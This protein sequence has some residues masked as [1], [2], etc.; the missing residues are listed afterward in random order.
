MLNRFHRTELH[1][2]VQAM[3]R[4]QAMSADMM[5]QSFVLIEKVQEAIGR[6]A[7]M[8]GI[9]AQKLASPPPPDYT[10]VLN[11]LVAAFRDI[12]VSAMQ[13]DDRKAIPAG[14]PAATIKAAI[15]DSTTGAQA[16]AADNPS[17]SAAAVP[18]ATAPESGTQTATRTRKPQGTESEKL[19]EVLARLQ[20]D[21]ERMKAELELLRQKKREDEEP[22][23]QI[24]A[25]SLAPSQP[26]LPQPPSAG[27]AA[28]LPSMS[29]APTREP[30]STFP[31]LASRNADCSCGSGRKYKKC[32]L[33]QQVREASAVTAGSSRT[34]ESDSVG[35]NSSVVPGAAAAQTGSLQASPSS[36]DFMGK[37]LVLPDG[38]LSPA[39]TELLAQ[40]QAGARGDDPSTPIPAPRVARVK[41]IE[42][43]LV[44]PPK[45]DRETAVAGGGRRWCPNPAPASTKQT[46]LCSRDRIQK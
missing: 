22:R 33:Q 25:S 43:V 42:T 34:T 6:A 21:N 4:V 37:P 40:L 45:M 10:P 20:A 26:A 46:A 15:G 19:A 16:V 24:K 31:R 41:Q 44:N 35:S 36:F 2:Q 30:A 11:N 13:R 7:E 23:P 38:V 9:A 17:S 32:C 12:G 14:E 27:S 8:E 39:L 1:A 18:A 29:P 3:F 28:S 5:E